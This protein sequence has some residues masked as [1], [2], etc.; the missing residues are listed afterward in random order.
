MNTK[1]P[2]GMCFGDENGTLW[3]VN[4]KGLT[5]E[6]IKVFNSPILGIIVNSENNKM[7]AYGKS[8][9]ILLY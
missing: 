5:L 2:Q 6:K 3:L 8:V 9:A 4:R 7:V 1:H